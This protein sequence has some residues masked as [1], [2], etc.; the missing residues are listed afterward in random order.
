MARTPTTAAILDAAGT[1]FATQAGITLR[2][3]PAPLFQ[4]LTLAALLAKPISSDMACDAA[5]E[6]RKAGATT[7]RRTLDTTWQQRVDALGR[8]H[9]RRFD[10]SMATRT[11]ELAQF[12]LDEHAGDVRRLAA[13]HD[14]DE[15]HTRLT[16]VPGI[17]PT[18]ADFVLREAQD[19]WPWVRPYLDERVLAGA[20]RL[21]LPGDAGTLRRR[22][23]GVDAARLASALVRVER[24]DDLVEHLTS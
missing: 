5:R 22:F 15:V 2:D 18:G 20:R 3:K 11:A 7:P 24:D 23:T 21:G 10:E 19:V 6:L 13:S 1:T 9:Y 4:L 16:D 12:L 14:V 17:G 8:A